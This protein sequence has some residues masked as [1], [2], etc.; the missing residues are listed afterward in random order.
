MVVEL[1]SRVEVMEG[2]QQRVEANIL[3]L[4]AHNVGKSAL[5]VRF[6]TR[7][8]IGEYGDIESVYSRVDRIDGQNICFNIWDSQFTQAGEK[9]L[10]W[11]DGMILVY[12]I[13]DRGSFDV[14]R[15]QLQ[16]I[17]GGRK[18]SSVPVLIVGNKRDLQRYRS[19]SSEE[20][21]L[22][23]LSQR[24]GF[25]EVSAAETYHGALLVFHRLVDLVRETR[26]L[27]KTNAGVRGIVRSVF[28][29][30]RAE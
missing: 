20:G 26:A 19:V 12:S 8:F 25:F 13:C 14:V 29:K 10:Q 28:G 6:L 15:Q 1:N 11:A 30:K 18:P 7:R 21:R 23:A 5:T 4:G 9:Q 16:Q 27:R 24:C 2:N 17:R 22:L 3:L